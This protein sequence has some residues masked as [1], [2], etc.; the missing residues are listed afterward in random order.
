M[1]KGYEGNVRSRADFIVPVL[2]PRLVVHRDV[3]RPK[4]RVVA[5]FDATVDSICRHSAVVAERIGE[6]V[7]GERE[8]LSRIYDQA[9]LID[10]GVPVRDLFG[11]EVD[12]RHDEL[13]P[14][15][16]EFDLGTKLADQAVG[17]DGA[18]GVDE[19]VAASRGED[20]DGARG[21]QARP[22]PRSVRSCATSARRARHRRLTRARPP[23]A[24]RT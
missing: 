8:R 10:V 16:A 18:Q 5:S 4:G 21:S 17:P 6:V 22:S 11:R 15:L 13:R 23:N 12:Q 24:R 9:R 19:V 1:R 3:G 20:A 7:E 2:W 14:F